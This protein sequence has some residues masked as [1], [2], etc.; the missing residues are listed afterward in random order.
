MIKERQLSWSNSP[1][2]SFF[3]VTIEIYCYIIIIIIEN[4][5]SPRRG[6]VRAGR[7]FVVVVV[8]IVFV[9]VYYYHQ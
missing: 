6:C 9:F 4:G 1:P 5:S 7:S 3:V 2:L 8:V